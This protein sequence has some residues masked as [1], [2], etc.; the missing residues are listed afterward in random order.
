M[1]AINIGRKR[2][3]GVFKRNLL[4]LLIVFFAA[5]AAR[6]QY[7]AAFSHY[8]ALQPYYNPAA[9][10]KDAKINIAAAYA[11]NFVG[12]THSPKTMYVA[13]DMPFMFLNAQHGVGL[14]L[15]NDQIGLFKHQNFHLQYSAGIRLGGGTLRV[16]AKVGLITENFDGSKLDLENSADP[17]F[18]KSSATGHGLDIDVGLYYKQKSWYAGLSAMHVTAPRV[19]LGE[20]NEIDIGGSYYLTGGCD[21][22][23][24]N[25][26]FTLH[27]SMILR[28]D[29]AAYRGDVT[30]RVE[31][32][33]G[34]R[35][36]E[37]GLSYSPGT[38]VTLLLGGDLHG[39]NIGYSYEA[40]TSALSPGNGSHE[41]CIGYKI[42]RNLVKRGR[43]KHKSVRLL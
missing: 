32:S 38:S 5:G 25:Q 43:N 11:M 6:A 24:N 20:L 33:D 17:V 7:D 37:A 21:I 2:Y 15:V 8:W 9:V 41:L 22:K 39:L 14:G 29:L 18:V 34:N 10:G 35:K 30:C 4:I 26:M 42:D 27:P 40:Y 16:G 13:A 23:M 28:T 31:Y 12:F 19:E 36:L 3:Y 1:N